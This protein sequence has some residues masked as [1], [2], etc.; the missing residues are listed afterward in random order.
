MTIMNPITKSLTVTQAKRKLLEIVD[1]IEKMKDMVTLT[2]NG[3]PTTVMM[4]LDDYESMV[5]TLEILSDSR[6]MASLKK[7]EQQRK[8]GKLL[9]D[10]EVWWNLTSV[11]SRPMRRNSLKNCLQWQSRP[12]APF[13]I[14]F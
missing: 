5:E 3:I 8:K 13:A 1:Q 10:E 4:S 11:V 14:S 2:R 6:V 12:F 9:T 7:S